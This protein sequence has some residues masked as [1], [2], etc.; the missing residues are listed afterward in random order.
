MDYTELVEFAKQQDEKAITELFELTSQKGYYVALKYLKN[1][2]DA[3]DIL[4]DAYVSALSKLDQLKDT[5]KFDKWLFQ[6][7]ANKAKNYL[8]KNKPLLF[9]QL[10]SDDEDAVSFEDTIDDNRIEFQPKENSDYEELK[11]ALKTLIDELPDDQRMCLLMYYYEEL[12]ISEISDAL[13][14]NNNTI[15]SRLNYAR[16]KVREKI[17][18][19]QKQGI[20]I[21]GVTPIPLLIWT[22]L[23]EEK[24]T[25]VPQ[26]ASKVLVSNV[27]Y[28][29][30]KT[31]A[32]EGIK[33]F[34]KTISSKTIAIASLSTLT[35]LSGVGVYEYMHRQDIYNSL[36]IEFTDNRVFE[37]GTEFNDSM[38]IL[39]HTGEIQSV[40]KVDM[41]KIG[42]QNLKYIVSKDGTDRSFDVM[43][44][45]KDT[46]EPI[47]VL[48]EAEIEIQVNDEFDPLLYI[49]EAYDEVDGELKDK[50]KV[51][52]P[53]D[54]NKTGDYKVIYSLTDGN[55]L[56]SE[57]ILN[58]AVK[59]NAIPKTEAKKEERQV[60]KQEKDNTETQKQN[61]DEFK[62]PMQ[63]FSLGRLG[64][65]MLVPKDFNIRFSALDDFGNIQQIMYDSNDQI[66]YGIS[67]V[68]VQIQYYEIGEIFEKNERY[69]ELH[70]KNIE[71]YL[72]RGFEAYDRGDYIVAIKRSNVMDIRVESKVGKGIYNITV[73]AISAN[74]SL[75]SDKFVN[76]RVQLAKDIFDS[77]H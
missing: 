44:E 66:H 16:K 57:A 51:D 7:I 11:S 43:I 26:I 35:V 50:I 61:K 27:T 74:G 2:E 25:V 70:L 3:Q 37:Y 8:V 14:L 77:I 72:S 36:M 1:K 56:K 20:H 60:D 71:A 24:A 67:E 42:S 19:L 52:N 47:L 40:N 15:K 73:Q 9:E 53:V 45:I 13:E 54:T 55:G 29:A 33:L 76:Q 21:Y 41:K 64:L 49:K 59:E 75:G 68:C 48:S 65:N 58:V 5:S 10:E 12:S 18:T 30:G 22:L 28:H 4:Q 39:D 31:V 32:K 6:I 17:E 23:E 34:G 46:K 69:N 62:Q 38:L 63:N